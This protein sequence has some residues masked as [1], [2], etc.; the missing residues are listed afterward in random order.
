MIF[1][2]F[3]YFR[4][5]FVYFRTQSSLQTPNFEALPLKIPIIVGVYILI[6][7]LKRPSELIKVKVNEKKIRE[8]YFI[9]YYVFA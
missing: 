6:F 3:L 5:N 2:R 4:L 9:D 8:R 1:Y 7:C